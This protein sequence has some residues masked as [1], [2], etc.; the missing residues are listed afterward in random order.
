[1]IMLCY[2]FAE[3]AASAPIFWRSFKQVYRSIMF[4]YQSWSARRA[5][6]A[7][8]DTR[9][10]ED[11]MLDDPA[12]AHEQVPVWAWTLGLAL[13]ICG[14]LIVGKLSFNMDVGVGILALLLAFLFSFIGVQASG[15]TDV[16]PIG[17]IA[18]ASQLVIGSA[19]GGQGSAIKTAQTTNLVAGSLAGIWLSVVLFVLFTEAYPCLLDLDLDCAAFGMPAVAAWRSVAIAVTAPALPVHPASAYTA[20]ALGAV[21]ALTVLAKHTVVPARYHVWVP[22][23][24]AVGLGF[25]VP[26][27]YY[28]AAMVLG[29]P[30]RGR[31]GALRSRRAWSLARAWPV[32]LPPC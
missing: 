23:W 9:E 3:I 29:A 20:L 10:A 5:G 25:I 13:S 32:C 14:T 19:T 1:M 15:T 12:P 30:R 31:C 27:V 6:R 17:V 18:K 4:E 22:N 16:N 7:F 28:P 21:A 8:T 26:Q 11:V 2:S 24:S